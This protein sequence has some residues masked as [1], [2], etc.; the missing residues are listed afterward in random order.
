MKLG[1][2]QGGLD[3]MKARTAEGLDNM[4]ARRRVVDI[5]RQCG[6]YNGLWVG[7]PVENDGDAEAGLCNNSQARTAAPKWTCRLTL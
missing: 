1:N 3:N 2:Y 6:Y 5:P 7:G 4:K